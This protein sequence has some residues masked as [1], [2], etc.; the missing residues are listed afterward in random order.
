M[1]TR[2]MPNSKIQMLK[3]Y[4]IQISKCQKLASFLKDSY[5]EPLAVCTVWE[6]EFWSLVFVCDLV[7]GISD[8]GL[9]RTISKYSFSR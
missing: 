7:L 8:L 9:K 1:A 6:F 5:T 4:Q 2:K 3:K